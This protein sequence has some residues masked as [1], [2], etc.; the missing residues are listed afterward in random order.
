MTRIVLVEDVSLT[1]QYLLDI[2][3]PTLYEVVVLYDQN[4]QPNIHANVHYQAIDYLDLGHWQTYINQ[5]DIV[6]MNALPDMFKDGL[7]Q[8][9]IDALRQLIKT[10]IVDAAPL[11]VIEYQDVVTDENIQTK[12]AASFQGMSV[13]NA[14]TVH[15]SLNAYARYLKKMSLGVIQVKGQPECFDIHLLN[16]KRPLIAMKQVMLDHGVKLTLQSNS[17]LYQPKGKAASFYFIQTQQT[18][19]T[20][21]VHFTPRLPWLMYQKTQAVIHEWVMRGFGSYLIKCLN[22]GNE[23]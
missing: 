2:L 14:Y 1:A 6:L 4:R 12:Q 5:A 19:Y 21:L 13:P 10:F 18:L 3:D 17:L 22:Q 7:W 15:Q 20:C 9:N 8:G 16:M 23:K 11:E